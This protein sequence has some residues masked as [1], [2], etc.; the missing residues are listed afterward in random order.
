M[1][2]IRS[3]GG[4]VDTAS[5]SFY[6]RVPHHNGASLSRTKCFNTLK[7]TDQ[8]GNDVVMKGD[9]CTNWY[10]PYSGFGLLIY[11]GV[12]STSGEARTVKAFSGGNLVYKITDIDVSISVS[13]TDQELAFNPRP[14]DTISGAALLRGDDTIIGSHFADQLYGMAGDDVLDG[15]LGSD[16]LDGGDGSDTADYSRSPAGVIVDLSS[17][18]VLGGH[19]VGDT[20]VSIENA[21]GSNSADDT[22]IGDDGDNRLY[23]NGGDD[24]LLGGLGNDYL[25]GGRG[26]D[27]ME[28]GP[29]DDT[30]VLDNAGDVF[31]EAADGGSDTIEVAHSSGL[32]E[33]I[34]NLTLIGRSNAD[35][36]GDDNDN[37]LRGNRGKNELYGRAGNDTIF[38]GG[39]K[40]KLWGESGDDIIVGD[41]TTSRDSRILNQRFSNA[42]DHLWG[43]DGND[44]LY[45]GNGADQLR[46]EAGDDTLFGDYSNWG[47]G[48]DKLWGGLG[49]DELY[50]GLGHDKLWGGEGD[51][52]L[53]GGPGYGK[54]QL[55]GEA[56]NDILFGGA[57]RDKLIGGDGDDLLFGNFGT[58]SRLQ[59]SRD[60]LIGGAGNDELHGGD[61]KDKLI[62]GDGNDL[63]FGDAGKDKLIGGSGHDEIYG[64]EDKDKLNGG[65][66][67]DWLDGGEG[68]DKLA[69]KAG[70]DTLV[71]DPADRLLHGGSG[72]DT[73]LFSGEGFL[74]GR[75]RAR[76]I[77]V[78]DTDN[79]V[80]NGLLLS[81]SDVRKLSETDQLLIAAD[82]EDAATFTGEWTFVETN[83]D[84]YHVF[85]A[86]AGDDVV[87]LLLDPDL[88]SNLEHL[89]A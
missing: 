44:E 80:A 62:G 73:L 72:E 61:S 12:W 3:T 22:L 24:I 19:A 35:G 58:D 86:M 65:D 47:S 36:F 59:D 42:R 57:G 43:G 45:G 85:T 76:S 34:E 51:D 56:G 63:L 74:D 52:L 68:R 14:I 5:L 13:T 6:I 77:E 55:R 37:E 89:I 48:N 67:D 69:A 15:G 2:T 20:L 4:P 31:I 17:A 54:D 70:N 30:Y 83:L 38:G 25:D 87:T 28:G 8:D 53:E 16:L 40:D 88:T 10:S 7:G 29:G 50:G 66:G 71:W 60:K 49:N 41:V 11:G 78:V 75:G 23:G 27:R 1:A 32:P 81:A 33:H 82:A 84:G 9:F 39:G 18:S 79:D 21:A 46:G 64:G 26:A